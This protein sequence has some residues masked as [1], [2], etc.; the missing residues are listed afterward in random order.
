MENNMENNMEP[1]NLFAVE[2]IAIRSS[3]TY[4]NK[5]R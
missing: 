5:N 4:K 2:K 1:C 3:W